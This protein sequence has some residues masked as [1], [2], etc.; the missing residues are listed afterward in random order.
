M[1]RTQVELWEAGLRQ[2]LDVVDHVLED[3]FGDLLPRRPNRPR[4]DAT[5]NPRYDGL[6]TVDSKFSM[7]LLSQSGP[8]YVIDVRL[9]AIGSP[10]AAQ[11][12]AILEEAERALRAALPESFPGRHLEVVREGRILR[13]TGDLSLEG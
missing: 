6:F 11:H 13:V 12:E 7:G 8:G 4:R 5:A 3:R 10:T 9:A 2:A 1:N